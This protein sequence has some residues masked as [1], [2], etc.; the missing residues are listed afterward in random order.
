MA[1][2]NKIDDQFV[3]KPSG[4]TFDDLIKEYQQKGA[5][6][7]RITQS[8]EA[9]DVIDNIP[10][11]Y[12]NGW[13]AYEDQP[14]IGYEG[15]GESATPI[16][17]NKALGGFTQNKD[18]VNY[19][20]DTQGNFKGAEK[21]STSFY[22]Q[23]GPMIMAA[24]TMG[25]GAGLL[26]NA[27]FPSLSGAS[28]AGAGG[29][30]AGGVNAGLKGQNI[31]KGALKGGLSGA[32]ALK[33]GDILGADVVGQDFKNLTLG[34]ANRAI[35][36]A[37]NPTARGALNIAS[38]YLP[39]DIN[40]GDTGLSVTDIL[41]GVNTAQAFTSGDHRR[42]FDAATNMFGASSSLLPQSTSKTTPNTDP[43]AVE[44]T[45]TPTQSV[46]TTGQSDTGPI[47][48][49]TD[50][51][52]TDISK[53]QKTGARGYGFSAGGDIDELLRLLRN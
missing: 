47:Q 42:M 9:G 41:K 51:F 7:Q 17:G 29:A 1:T 20:Y 13:S 10:I 37:Q 8:G 25:G 19:H 28:A 27:L 34:D 11:Q 35:S 30:L 5:T 49:M 43:A 26:G 21:D 2:S 36:F 31:L 48:L 24:M 40:L 52:G 15:Q 53:A 6:E 16:Y 23:F 45:F 18:G 32:G 14:I 4:L 33:L 50:I 46:A 3:N 38:K 44:N 12:G 39:N 22:D